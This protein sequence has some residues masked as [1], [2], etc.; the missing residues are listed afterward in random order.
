MLRDD[1]WV[2]NLINRNKKV[3]IKLVMGNKSIF[4]ESKSWKFVLQIINVSGPQSADAS[5][6][7]ST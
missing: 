1:F 4:N 2:D 3:F 6:Q 7:V 5:R